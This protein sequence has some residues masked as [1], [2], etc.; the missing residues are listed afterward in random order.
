MSKHQGI[1]QMTSQTLARHIKVMRQE[2]AWSQAQLADITVL[3]VRTIQRVEDE[4]RCSSETLLALAAAF[5]IDVHELT[6]LQREGQVPPTPLAKV[7]ARF[8][9]TL[10]RLANKVLLRSLPAPGRALLA[11]AALLPSA[12]F[13]TAN[14]L[15][16]V[17]GLP[18]LYL[19]LK[20]LYANPFLLGLFNTA[21]PFIFL[22]G[23]GWAVLVNLDAMITLDVAAAKDGIRGSVYFRPRL[24]NGIV[25]GLSSLFLAALLL[26]LV[27]E[28]VNHP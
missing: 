9:S 5:E 18:Q 17:Y 20:A 15:Y 12:Y 28:N 4:G 14:V 24:A 19:P 11:I 22:G 16:F 13:V 25:L 1:E 27:V 7:I 6:R 21:S 8:T 23:L 3:N 10:N 26:Y 2:R